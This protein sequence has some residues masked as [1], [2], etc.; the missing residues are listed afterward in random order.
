MQGAGASGPS[1]SV[2]GDMPKSRFQSI[3]FALL[4]VVF[5]VVAM[6]F[7]NQA[8]LDGRLS[9]IAMSRSLHEMKF[10]IPICFVMSFFIADP[11]ASR[12][13]ERSVTEDTDRIVRTVF[14]SS[15][16]VSMM[17]PMMS[18]WATLIFQRPGFAD[19][20]PAWF[21]TIGKNLPMAFFWQVLFC[22]PLVRFLFS[23]IFRSAAS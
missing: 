19:F 5:M 15:V 18:F 3:V 10:M 9:W 11:I 16:T 13:V 21:T 6:E 4:M 2:E 7:Y 23:R 12:I 14:R 22:G 8:L 17:C 1:D 20:I